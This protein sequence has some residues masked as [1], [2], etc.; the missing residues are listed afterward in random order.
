[1]PVL[2]GYVVRTAEPGPT[3]AHLSLGL[4]DFET[5]HRAWWPTRDSIVDTSCRSAH[6][7]VDNLP[8]AANGQAI[9]GTV[10]RSYYD[11]F[12]NRIHVL[13]ALLDVGNLVS[14][15]VRTVDVWNAYATDRTLTGIVTLGEGATL[16]GPA[17]FPMV[18][19]G[20]QMTAWEVSVTTTGPVTID[21][22]VTWNFTGEPDATM[23]VTG[24]RVT[25]WM[26][27]PNWSTGVVERIEFRTDILK[28]FD[29]SEQR[30]ALLADGA[31]WSFEFRWNASG[32]AMRLIENVLYQWAGQVW[33][34]PLFPQGQQLTADLAPGATVITAT[35]TDLDYHEGGLA[36]LHS[37]D[38]PEIYEAVEILS[39]T[40][41]AITTARPL[42]NA[43][44]IGTY[45]YPARVARMQKTT[46]AQRFTG[47][48]IYGT[49]KF[50]LE[51]QLIR[52]PA[53]ETL[54]RGYPIQETKPE[55]AQD[56][57]VEYA[58]KLISIDLGIRRPTIDDP[59]GLA[60]PVTAFRWTF[61]TRA[62]V[63]AFRRWLFARRGRQKAIWLPTFADDLVVKA[64]ISS[65]IVNLD[66]EACG[67]VN[68]VAAGVNRRD[69]RIQM[70]DGT[71][72]YRRTSEHVAVDATTERVTLSSPLGV[73]YVP[74][75]F[76][77]ISWMTLARLDADA[78]EIAH[79][80]GQVSSALTTLRAPRTSA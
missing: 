33:A 59:S 7:I 8:V 29:G 54:Y 56:P 39:F 73:N 10:P 62:A 50:L 48:D 13:P 14:V 67:L 18:F 44:P 23:H 40:S 55:W 42:V 52:T 72:Y 60:E 70:K 35:T 43:W 37:I 71:V 64:P 6:A 61:T 22:D 28:K 12:Y 68:Y 31:K 47:A 32:T 75:D 20:Y 57:S 4:H 30:T 66:V 77:Q 65:G 38:R 41:S 79:W 26:I 53:T 36:F 5:D 11:D 74:A 16:D 76:A 9:A 17:S 3:N 45:I 34:L 69:I 27:P 51:E 25:A 80:T 19:D 78:V 58:R 24:N 46:P 1:M 21:I 2:D 15:Q 49:A 63:E